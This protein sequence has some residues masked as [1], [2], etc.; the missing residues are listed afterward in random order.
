MTKERRSFTAEE[1]LSILQEGRF[2]GVTPPN[3]LD[4][5]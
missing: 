2:G 1:R 4:Q 3:L 5:D